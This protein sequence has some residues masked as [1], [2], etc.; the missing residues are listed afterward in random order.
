MP[1]VA[2]ASTFFYDAGSHLSSCGLVK[3]CYSAASLAATPSFVADTDVVVFSNDVARV[4]A[5][6]SYSARAPRVL[7]YPEELV[8]LAKRWAAAVAPF[9]NTGSASAKP[10]SKAM[11]R[12]MVK[13]TLL[14][15]HAVSRSRRVLR[16]SRHESV[17]ST[18]K[19]TPG[20]SRRDNRVTSRHTIYH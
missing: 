4:H 8:G 2:L 18:R 9:W 11:S 7:V 16:A 19:N 10:L 5:E 15:W 12:R 20:I 1:R 13:Q 17:S 3:W 6:C 14:K